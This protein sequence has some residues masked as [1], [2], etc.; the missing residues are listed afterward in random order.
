MSKP[1][2]E[3]INIKTKLIQFKRNS[4]YE[5]NAC[6]MI[7]KVRYY[8][9]KF[10][11]K[12]VN[13]FFEQH[14]LT[15]D[16]PYELIRAVVTS[17]IDGKQITPISEEP[18]HESSNEDLITKLLMQQQAM[19][20]Q[21][22]AQQMLFNPSLSP[23]LNPGTVLNQGSYSTPTPTPALE[24]TEPAP[25]LENKQQTAT[26]PSVQTPSSTVPDKVSYEPVDEV[27]VTQESSA[28]DFDDMDADDDYITNLTSAFSNI[29]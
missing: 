2:G 5:V 26:T 28:P 12:L 13:D 27:D 4:P 19:F 22:I 7:D 15:M 21:L 18:V 25:A 1:K 6:N 9:S 3:D 23:V 24:K 16:S 17:Y 20:Q 14:H 29:L 11:I 8:Q 10:I